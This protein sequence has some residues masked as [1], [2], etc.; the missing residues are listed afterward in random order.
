MGMATPAGLQPA[1]SA[2]GKPCSMQLSYGAIGGH[3]AAR[4]AR[5]KHDREGKFTHPRS[6]GR[7][8]LADAGPQ[9]WLIVLKIQ[10]LV[11]NKPRIGPCR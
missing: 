1:T 11:E 3:L 4:G 5:G 8:A 7:V 9:L 6:E 10:Y 2:L